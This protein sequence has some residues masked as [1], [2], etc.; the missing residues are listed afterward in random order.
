MRI[1]RRYS[2]P[3]AIAA[4][5]AAGALAAHHAWSIR[6]NG[7]T[8]LQLICTASFAWLA[9]TA[10]LPYF[11]RDI[12]L[13]PRGSPGRHQLHHGLRVTAIVPAH[14]EDP[15]MFRAM[16]DSLVNQSRQPERIHVIE[17]GDPRRGYTP[18]LG[19][20]FDQWRRDVCPPQVEAVYSFN[21]IPDKREAQ[22]VAIRA[23]QTADVYMTID[24][25]CTASKHAIAYGVAPF[26][27]RRVTSV[28][29]L[30]LGLNRTRNLLTRLVEPSFVCASLNGRASASMVGGV[31]VNSG[32]LAFYRGR[33]VRQYLDHY[34]THTVAGRKISNGD[35]AMLTRYAALEG[36]TVFQ[37]NC[38]G[39]TLHPEKLSHLTKQ[40]VRWWR[41]FFWGNIWLI[42]AFPARRG[43][44]WLTVWQFVSFLWMTAALPI[45]AIVRPVETGRVAWFVLAWAVALSYLSTARYLTIARPGESFRA[46]LAMWALAPLAAPLTLYLG[47]VL[48][49]VGLFTCLKTGWSTRQTVDVGFG[50]SGAAVPVGYE[51]GGDNSPTQVIDSGAVARA[52]A[53]WV[54]Q[55]LP[56]NER[57]NA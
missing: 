56:V 55:R 28:A 14:N 16:L 18:T 57:V 20:V 50:A 10:I 3:V 8:D 11:H 49:Y 5:A 43:L 22:A 2:T 35:D 4:F 25:D 44:W 21:P 42:R 41:S 45:A 9:F 29:G 36:D 6:A 54:R 19:G 31:G 26:L 30:L 53:E 15:T 24:S 12:P 27:R 13:P 39:Y 52:K 32:G 33:V 1:R 48:S 38:W 37:A 23:D 51:F 46:H 40:R 7:L 34:L 47:F 17:N